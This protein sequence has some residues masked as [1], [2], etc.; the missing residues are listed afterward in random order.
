MGKRKQARIKSVVPVRIWGVD[1]QGKPFAEVAHTLDISYAG[2][3][4][5]GVSGTVAAGSVIALQCR[6]R[7]GQFEVTW[8]GRPGSSRAKQL[9]LKNL[10]P[11]R[12]IFGLSLKDEYLVDDYVGAVEVEGSDR[13]DRETR[14]SPRY[15]CTGGASFNVAN[16]PTSAWA[17]LQD[18]SKTGTYLTTL[19]P[20][21]VGTEVEMT[22]HLDEERVQVVGKVRTCHPMVGMGVEFQRFLNEDA[23]AKLEATLK[24]LREGAAFPAPR[25]ITVKPDAAAI[26]MRLQGVTKE[27]ESIDQLIQ[28]GPVDPTVLGEF[29]DAVSQ[30]RNTA[31]ALQRWME[32]EQSQLSPYPV[33][34]YLNAERIALATRLCDSLNNEFQRSDLRRQK[35]S[36]DGLLA[37]VEKLFTRLAGIDLSVLGPD[38]EVEGPTSRPEAA[39]PEPRPVA[40]PDG[41]GGGPSDPEVS[42]EW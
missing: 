38:V 27:L 5:G 10:D 20:L 40:G 21:P 22:V 23:E 12:D 4:L 24:R 14:R 39:A 19:S 2:V 29:R 28:N 30:V 6:H 8:A 35:K 17:E 32:L 13:K 37:A 25:G 1:G 16:S 15:T 9:G 18:I 7:K 33:L 26:S 42:P 36:L 11:A 31:W 41:P 3:R 34:S